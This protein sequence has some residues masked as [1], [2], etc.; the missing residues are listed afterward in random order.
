MKQNPHVTLL[1]D[2]RQRL[3]LMVDVGIDGAA[4]DTKE[5]SR[6]ID[7]VEPIRDNSH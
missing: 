4:M 7:R 2:K 3:F 6:L 1:P 5:A